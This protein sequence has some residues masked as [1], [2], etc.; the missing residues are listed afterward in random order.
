MD[1]F[2]QFDTTWVKPD[3]EVGVTKGK[4]SN[5]AQAIESNATQAKETDEAS[6]PGK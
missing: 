1:G 3:E 6:V 4:E 5:V 2:K